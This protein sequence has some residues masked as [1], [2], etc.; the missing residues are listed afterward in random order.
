MG[1]VLHDVVFTAVRAAQDAKKKYGKD[2][3]MDATLGS[4]YN[5][6]GIMV[7][8]DSV[9][10]VFNDIPNIQKAKYA[11]S[12]QGNIEYREAVKKWLGLP[13]AEVVA[14]PGGSGAVSI[15]FKN[16]LD[17]GDKILL[18]DVY[19]AP[20]LVMAVEQKLEV[21]YY[22]MFKG[23]HFDVESFKV[24]CLE[25]MKEQGKVLVAINDPAHNPTGYT[26]SM[27]EW[28]Q[29][30]EFLNE[31]AN[32]GKVMLL[33]DIAYIDFVK[34]I[35]KSRKHFKL[36]KNIN[37]NLLISVTFSI[38]KTLTAYGLRVGA[39]VIVGKKKDSFKNA[40][41]HSAR[42]VWSNVNNGGMVLFSE[43]MN[44]QVK[45]NRYIEEKEEFV[46][47]LADRSN[48]FLKEAKD[49]G[50]D[51]YPHVEGFFVTVK[52]D[53]SI[54]DKVHE[55]LNEELIFTINL[56]TGPRVALCSTSLDKVR[57]LAGK[58]KDIINEF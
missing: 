6:E 20:Y 7:A 49:V 48:L 34:D 56:P 38:S 31:L 44:D 16:S 24:K 35:K 8:L 54:K 23:D 17:Q 19:W 29:V 57:V 11:S 47:M 26:M 18:P 45:L 10:D 30:M 50:L 28:E 13:D 32:Q 5:E 27:N 25:L 58:I 1:K 55:R 39:A 22:Q 36:F 12:L 51:T 9:W 14:T 15:T 37:D 43:I 53:S 4:L 21:D 41:V 3:V 42:S 40:C 2:K 52:V 46:K 33:N